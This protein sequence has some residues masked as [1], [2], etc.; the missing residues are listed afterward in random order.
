MTLI[1][2]AQKIHFV[3]IGGIG[4]SGLARFCSHEGK[5]V[6][7]SDSTESVI[8]EALQKEAV[9]VQIGHGALPSEI[10]VL[11][12]SE[13]IPEENLERQEAVDK[14]IPTLSYFEALG[15]WS[16][17]M[18]TIAI[19]GTHGKTTTTAMLSLILEKAGLD[20]NALIGSNLKE[21]EGKNVRFGASNLF[22]V[23]ACEYRRN[24]RYL[25]PEVLGILN[26][27]LDHVDYFKSF[28]DYQAAFDELA[29]QSGQCVGAEDY[30]SYEG[31]LGIPGRHNR[32]NAGLA[33]HV[34]RILGVSDDVI[35]ASLAEFT[36]TWRRFEYRGTCNGALVYDDYAHHPT[37]IRATLAAVREKHPEANVL[38]VFQPH[39]YNRTAGLLEEF[40]QSF[41]E[42]D[43]VI[44]PNIYE[45]RDSEADK[46]AVSA[47]KLV[48]AITRHHQKV[49]F[50]NGIDNTA[51]LLL[52]EAKAGD[53]ILIMGA[54]P[55]DVL[56]P[57]ILD[58][59][60]GVAT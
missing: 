27:E 7:G 9:P 18:K 53:F 1:D 56:I 34:A 32:M 40:A 29:S 30:Q 22:V 59:P 14:N 17:K 42:A 23:E 13:A 20:P 45:V 58:E 54:G 15:Q 37:E 31:P 57:Q 5:V 33:A 49:E 2:S 25:R 16:S 8:T 51:K 21:F 47:E 19:A 36:G 26:V 11:V 39:Q 3:G 50:G 46:A 24:F 44:I 52:Q 60:V 43:H 4:M 12:Y 41:D 28:E 35:E 10:D 48:E 55:I 38:A 6:T